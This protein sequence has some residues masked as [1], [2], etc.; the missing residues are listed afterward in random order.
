MSGAADSNKKQIDDQ[1][2]NDS[3]EDKLKLVLSDDKMCAYI[4]LKT[5]EDGDEPYTEEGILSFLADA[6]IKDDLI[7][8]PLIKEIIEEEN[9]GQE[10]L[11][12][13]GLP[14]KDGIDGYF[15]YFFHRKEGNGKPR[16]LDDGSVDY[17][18]VNTVG[19]VTEGDLIAIYNPSVPGHFGYS[20]KGEILKPK[21]P[22]GMPVPKLTGCRYEEESYSYYA[23]MDGKVEATPSSI[24]VTGSLEI[25]RNINVAYGSIY[26]IGDVEIY[27]DV[28][29]GVEI[30]ASGNVTI[31]G[32][33][34]GS[35]VRA[36]EN[37][38]IK[39]GVLGDE[40][41]LIICGGDLDV[42]FMQY[43]TVMAGGEIKAKSILDCDLYAGGMVWIEDKEGLVSG[44]TMYS[45]VGVDGQVFGN[46]RNVK[47]QIT[48]GKNSQMLT[49]KLEYVKV[50]EELENK[51]EG[52]SRREFELGRI[53]KDNSS[54]N[55]LLYI[56]RQNKARILTEK[57]QTEAGYA[58]IDKMY[59][60][61]A[62][63]PSITGRKFYPGVTVRID[64][65]EKRIT[66]EMI[67]VTFRIGE[68]GISF[69]FDKADEDE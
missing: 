54:M 21:V 28:D 59:S 57:K 22:R 35:S 23:T 9:Y 47:T 61:E 67:R 16:I 11:I 4:L 30:F 69:S 27:G 43:A 50:I 34:Q 10:V 31:G 1:N 66:D 55:N 15:E 46:K 53:A 20:V 63:P 3:G 8:K 18:S 32:T 45:T 19:M 40:N 17:T 2:N 37:L 26:F 48:V 56:V 58:A 5:P 25:N 13:E 64:S 29:S 39:G 65:R 51:L 36:G 62:V 60:K 12:A 52:V 42:K 41:T 68:D 49:Q 38:T 33:L 14:C 24:T 7:D 44:G 6:G